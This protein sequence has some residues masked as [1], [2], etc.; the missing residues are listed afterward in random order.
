VQIKSR[1]RELLEQGRFDTIAQLASEKRRV[2]GI[3]VSL[4]FDMDPQIAWR[5]VEALGTAA[6]RVAADDPD[7]VR[8]HLRRLYWL[9]SEESG[10]ICWRAPEAMAEIVRHNAALFADYIPIIV[11]LVLNMA[12]EDLAHFKAGTLWAIGRLGSLAADHVEEVRDVVMAALDDPDPQIRGTAAWCLGELGQT[13]VLADR[14]DLLADE[15]PVTF[16]EGESLE[17]TSV[18]A[19]VGRTLSG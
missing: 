7:Y 16:Y 18:A 17:L 5:A 10:G 9:I 1:L 2:L 13:E 8:E 19:L 12:E 6:R 3:L 11:F 4:T 15:A 14:P